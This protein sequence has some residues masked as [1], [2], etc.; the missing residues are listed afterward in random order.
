V[1]YY[2]LTRETREKKKTGKWGIHR[3]ANPTGQ[4]TWGNPL[5]NPLSDKNGS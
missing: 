5:S 4:E 3:N 2:N 1:I